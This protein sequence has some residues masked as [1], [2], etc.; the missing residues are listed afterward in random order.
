M[1]RMRHKHVILFAGAI[2][3][4]LMAAFA[5]PQAGGRTG[6]AVSDDS[7]A[8]QSLAVATSPAA[9]ARNGADVEIAEHGV[10]CDGTPSQAAA[11]QALI[12]QVSAAGGGNFRWRGTIN[13][14]DGPITLKPNVS[15][16]GCGERASILKFPTDFAASGKSAYAMPWSGKSSQTQAPQ[17][18]DCGI[19]G[20]GGESR[21]A[22]LDGIP[23]VKTHGVQLGPNDGLHRVYVTGFNSG[24]CIHADHNVLDQ[25]KS[26][27]N[28]LG[29]Y[30]E[31]QES[32]WV[33]PAFDIKALNLEAVWSGPLRS[34]DRLR[35]AGSKEPGARSMCKTRQTG[36]VRR[37]VRNDA[38]WS[39]QKRPHTWR[40][41]PR[42]CAA[43]SAKGVAN[44]TAGGME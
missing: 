27:N 41:S 35:G 37:V 2:G 31:D 43:W 21:P 12:D 15:M 32:F 5:R 22:K 33:R 8:G 38:A 34:A 25:V 20:P 23:S 9:A 3:L 44:V 19:F 10:L 7:N 6:D 13:C 40:L 26:A 39:G 17:L 4:G 14:S 28:F 24:V 1:S 16:S 42:P 11:L 29:V 36:P 30:Y 18:R